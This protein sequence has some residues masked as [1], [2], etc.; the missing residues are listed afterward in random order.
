MLS[1][2][3]ATETVARAAWTD[4]QD[5]PLSASFDPYL[6]HIWFSIHHDDD[7][8]I[9]AWQFADAS[10]QI[11]FHRLDVVD[12]DGNFEHYEAFEA[13]WTM[14]YTSPTCATEFPSQV[15]PIQQGTDMDHT[16]S[17]RMVDSS[18]FTQV[19]GCTVRGLSVRRADSKVGS[20]RGQS[21]AEVMNGSG[22][23]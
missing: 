5:D 19:V 20:F 16:V 13:E 9:A 17:A 10:G 15:H 8:D 18:I 14:R 3:C 21:F 23:R 11:P 6:Q 1:T 4:R 12:H 7:P 2:V 22:S